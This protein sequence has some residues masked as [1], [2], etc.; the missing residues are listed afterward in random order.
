MVQGLLRKKILITGSTGFVGSNLARFLVNQ[1]LS[2]HI[3]IRKD[4]NLWRISDILGKLK[5]HIIDLNDEIKTRDMVLRVK[6]KVIFHCAVYGGY[7]FQVDS[8]RI[9]QTNIFGTMN[10]L[11][12][13][14]KSGF[15][16]F[17]NTGSSSEYGLKNRAMRESDL[18]EPVTDYA[19]AKSTATL[20]CCA[21]AKR[22]KLP[23]VTLRLFSAYGPYEQG[24]RL[25]PSVI[26]SCLRNK[27]PELST[28]A[29]VRDFVFIED[30]VNAYMQALKHMNSLSGEVINIGSAREY[31]VKEVIDKITSLSP[32]KVKPLWKKVVNPR[33]EP[34]SWQA[35][36][37]KAKKMLKWAPLFSL[38][39]GLKKTFAWF[40]D[41]RGLYGG[42]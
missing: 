17:I 23:I 33:I 30:A 22:E 38:N 27:D 4:S 42:I 12:A 7:H 40:S 10:L 31:S 11:N 1:G 25:I 8:G 41:N 20:F 6:P 16:C 14:V 19:L 37:S 29:P 34:L 26:L 13:C 5:I 24:H 28:G 15:E 9:I 39:E 3:F 21:L 2:P 35:D 36:I 32:W 18:L